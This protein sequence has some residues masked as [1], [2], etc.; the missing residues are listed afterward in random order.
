MKPSLRIL[1]IL[2]AVLFLISMVGCGETPDEDVAEAE[3]M[4]VEAAE[5]MV[6]EAVDGATVVDIPDA[7]LHAAILSKLLPADTFVT[8]DD[9]LK[10]TGFTSEDRDIVNLTGLE[11][12]TNLEGLDLSGNGI[13]DISPLKELKNLWSVYLSGNEIV[14]ISPSKNSKNCRG[15]ILVAMG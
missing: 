11:Y 9:M 13:V 6:V 3:D 8:V 5:D 7:A 15:C 14:D 4:V 12:A 2:L 1:G 10:L